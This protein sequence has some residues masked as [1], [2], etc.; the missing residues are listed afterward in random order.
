[1]E[2]GFLLIVPVSGSATSAGAGGQLVK[3]H[4]ETNLLRAITSIRSDKI[5][6][7]IISYF[8]GGDPGYRSCKINRPTHVDNMPKSYKTTSDGSSTHL[9]MSISTHLQMS[10]YTD[11]IHAKK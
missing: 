7:P 3:R 2:K 10:I 1:M 11:A 6:I 9:Q 5:Y 4:P 8:Q